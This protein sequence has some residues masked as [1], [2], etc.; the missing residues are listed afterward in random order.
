MTRP[1]H[2]VGSLGFDDA[3]SAFRAVAETLGPRAPRYP[4]GEPGARNYWIRWQQ[5]TFDA[6][7]DF[8][9][10]EVRNIEGY[11]DAKKRP[12]FAIRD[13]AD[14]AN[15]HFEKLGYAD[16]ALKSWAIFKRLKEDGTIPT[17]VRFMVALPTACALVGGFVGPEDQAIAEPAIEDAFRRE[18]ETMVA[19]IPPDQ[20]AIQWDCAWEPVGIDGGPPLYYDDP[21]GGSIERFNRQA[22]FVPEPVEM[23][24]HLCYGDPG[25]KHIVEPPSLETCVTLANGIAAGSPRPVNW[26]HM[27]VPRDRSDDAY[28]KPLDD[29]KLRDE[30]TLYVGLV[31]YTDGVEGAAA[32]MKAADAHA[33]DYGIATECGFGRREPE[34]IPTLLQL[35]VSIAEG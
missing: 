2:L 19:E 24:F 18:I 30:T 16:E 32:R 27:P 8:E 25:H 14:R 13:G 15:L 35:H 20:L 23:G 12:Y 11:K 33:K 10:R 21:V 6:H 22:G 17:G 9:L 7:P 29:L 26:I 3:E 1:V 4:D 31:H 34:T 5:Q 28:F